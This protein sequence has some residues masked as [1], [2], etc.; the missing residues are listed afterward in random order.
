MGDK[1]FNKRIQKSH[2]KLMA[3]AQKRGIRI[4]TRNEREREERDN[5]RGQRPRVR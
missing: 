5:N 3:W 4:M 1:S 2:A